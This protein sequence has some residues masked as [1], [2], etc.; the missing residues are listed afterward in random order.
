MTYSSCDYTMA[1]LRRVKTY[2]LKHPEATPATVAR[3]MNLTE[4]TAA[5]YMALAEPLP[6]PFTDEAT[7]FIF[8]HNLHQLDEAEVALVPVVLLAETRVAAT[9]RRFGMLTG[10]FMD[11][12]AGMR[13]LL[14]DTLPDHDHARTPEH[15]K[16]TLAQ[17]LEWLRRLDA[18]E[19]TRKELA[20]ELGLSKSALYWQID[21][22]RELAYRYAYYTTHGLT[23]RQ[24]WLVHQR[25]LVAA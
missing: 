11:S 22:S 23:T 17:R 19:V 9:A 7:D 10:Y 15:A 6:T 16:Y 3:V 12:A 1:F 21:S 24:A 20:A 4:A 8:R 14:D 18:K 2:T 25:L 5:K 13:F